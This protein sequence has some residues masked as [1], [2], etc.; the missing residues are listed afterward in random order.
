MNNIKPLTIENA[1]IAANLHKNCFIQN[2]PEKDFLELLLKKTNLGW[3]Y[4]QHKQLIAIILINIV[5]NES[6]ILTICV[7]PI[8]RNKYIAQNLLKYI[9]NFLYSK[10]IKTLFL[11]VNEID[12]IAQHLYK[13]MGF[14]KIGIRKNYY[15]TNNQINDAVVMAFKF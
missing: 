12:K 14:I 11:E 7:D 13:K 1:A 2:W 5:E 10:K 8:Y 6:E 3:G 9:I 15:K 4:Y